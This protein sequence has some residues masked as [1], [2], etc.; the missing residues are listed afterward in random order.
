VAPQKMIANQI[1]EATT[2]RMAWLVNGGRTQCDDLAK[3][4]R[5]K[6]LSILFMLEYWKVNIFV[7]FTYVH[8]R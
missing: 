1:Y 8:L 7:L 4:F 3:T 6:R 2:R 5:V